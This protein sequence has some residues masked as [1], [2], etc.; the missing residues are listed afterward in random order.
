MKRLRKNL[1]CGFTLVELLIVIAIIGALSATMSVITTGT[2]AKAKAAAIASNVE[3]CK[4]AAVMYTLNTEVDVSDKTADDVLA[5]VIKTWKDFSK[6]AVKYEAVTGTEGQGSEK[7]AI[8]VDFTGDPEKE[9]IK[10]ELAK[11]KG[12]GKYGDDNGDS[13]VK[14]GK[15]KVVLTTGEITSETVTTNEGS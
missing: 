1:R 14:T 12:Y 2:T 9:A 13:R 11:I 3:A 7:W 8:T 15:F 4:S 10:T 6:G 5:E